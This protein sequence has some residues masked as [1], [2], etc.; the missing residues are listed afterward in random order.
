VAEQGW[1]MSTE[2]ITL[3]PLHLSRGRMLVPGENARINVVGDDEPQPQEQPM[4]LQ[5][6]LSVGL[7]AGKWCS[8]AAS[9]DLPSDQR[10]ED[11][12]AMVFDTAE[13]EE[14]VE[15]LGAPE[16]HIRLSSDKPA[17]MLAARISDV[18]P[19]GRAT[20]VT[21]G[22]L[23]L[24]HRDSH[25]QPSELEPGKVYDIKL[26]CNYIAQRFPAG[27]RIRLSLSTS[28]WPLAWPTPE[29]ARLRLYPSASQLHLPVRREREADAELRDMG[30]PE[31]DHPMAV[32]LIKPG[33]RDWQVINNLRNNRVLLHVVSNDAR[34]RLDDINWTVE[35]KVDEKY[36]YQH[37]NY[38]TLRGEVTSERYFER[39][40]WTARTVTK[41][42]LTSTK[43]HFIIRATLDAY[44]GDVRIFS[45]SWDEQVNRD[46]L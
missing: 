44:H 46:F 39:D 38:D 29:P 1:P 18:A 32:S 27:H 16:L 14:A 33:E 17:A 22:I 25:E 6:P 41:T 28:Y 10:Q 9:I 40:D 45:K 20:R 31:L 7:F 35:K 11:G 4:S 19:D 26:R 42:V 12:G 3:N 15:I 23:N 8:Y 21:Y 34:I 2:R 36:S 5:S 13:L 24:T 30:T 43:T 37:N